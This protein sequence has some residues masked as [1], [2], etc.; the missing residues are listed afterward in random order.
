MVP[1]RNSTTAAGTLNSW[2]VP[3]A[4]T[5]LVGGSLLFWAWAGLLWFVARPAAQQ[6]IVIWMPPAAEA[7]LE[8]GGLKF[9]QMRSTKPEGNSDAR[10]R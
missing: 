7:T 4:A 3:I 1:Q 9:K 6:P 8:Q 2:A 5:I 10:A